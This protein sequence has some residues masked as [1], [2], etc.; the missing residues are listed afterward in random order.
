MKKFLLLLLS[1]LIITVVADDDD[2]TTTGGFTGPGSQP[3]TV[4]VKELKNVK[5]DSRV[6]LIGYIVKQKKN[7]DSDFIFKDET[8]KTIVDIDSEVFGDRKINDKVKISICG[9][10]EKDGKDKIDVKKLEIV[11]EDKKK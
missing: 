9:E 4:T 5:H 2:V 11:K 6:L 7:S 8:G 10:F 1:A 3:D